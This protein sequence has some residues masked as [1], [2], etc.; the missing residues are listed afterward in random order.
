VPVHY[1]ARGF[2][3]RL[4]PRVPDTDGI[5]ASVLVASANSVNL[6]HRQ[7][8]CGTF[9]FALFLCRSRPG[10]DATRTFMTRI[11][12]ALLA[13]TLFCTTTVRGREATLP[14]SRKAGAQPL[15]AVPQVAVAVTDVRGELARDVQSGVSTPL[16]VAAEAAVEVSPATH[17]AWEVVP[18]GRI[19]RLRI[20]SSGATDLSLGFSRFRLFGG[21][22]LHLYSETEDY[23]QGAFTERDNK[24]HGQLW[25][26]VVPGDRLVIEL[27]VPDNG[28][29]PDLL[30]TQVNRGYRDLFRRKN[31]LGMP[32]AGVCENDVICTVGDPWRNEIRSVARY[33]VNGVFLCTGSLI[34]NVSGDKKNFFLTANHCGITAGNASSVVVYWNFESP[35]C[36]QQGGGSLAQNQS[37][38]TFRMSKADV[39]V[40]LIELEDVPDTAF[41][42]Y[43]AGWDRT[44]VA[45]PGAVGIHHPNGDEKS[46]SFSSATLLSV[47][48]CIGTGGVNTH[49][50]VFWNDGVTEPGSS[51]SGIWNP[52]TRRLVGFL[53]GGLSSCS[54]P[55][56]S[57]CYGKFSVAWDSGTTPASR[58]RD[59]LD[60]LNLN[61]NFVAGLDNVVIVPLTPSAALA[62]AALIGES[63]SPGNGVMDPNESVTVSF[64]VT[65][66]GGVALTNLVGTLLPGLGVSLPSGPQNY[67]VMPVGGANVSRSFTFIATGACGG[68]ITVRLQL[69]EG[70]VN[71]GTFTN[72]FT[73]GTPNIAMAQNFDAVVVPALPPGWTTSA[74]NSGSLW[75]STSAFRDTLPRSI[76]APAPASVGDSVVTSPSLF[77]G[78][79][80]AQLTF[81]HKYDF[82]NTYDGGVLEISIG[83]GAFVDILSSGGSFLA[84]GYTTTISSS[85]GN[86]LGGRMAWSGPTTG[87]ITTI[88]RLPAAA[89]GQ[90]VRLRWRAGTDSSASGVGW[91]VDTVSVSDG[92]VCC[93]GLLTPTIVNLRR[94]GNNVAFSFPSAAGQIYNVEFKGSLGTTNWQL[95]QSITGDGAVKHLTNS[96]TT[97]N[98]F[99]RLRSP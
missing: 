26:P 95:L 9:R 37:G 98:R 92:V 99:F 35:V 61:S 67:G 65:N 42:V 41:G 4:T 21:A 13:A 12:F 73:L 94:I 14:Y 59:W 90:S 56:E 25:T 81:R 43:Y 66:T 71:L 87:F 1:Q 46:I 74:T 60:P 76:F 15:A 20:I 58:L 57:D 53:S 75:V 6:A 49:W 86:S 5:K 31:E 89:A 96:F 10:Q 28:D 79:T 30:L 22:T 62:G 7:I 45:S 77:V 19:W 23:T 78:T 40:A 44:A 17:G 32:K 85:F 18:G 39:D 51:G 72:T 3:A 52:V 55:E 69:Q 80:T 84:G 97:T 88:A 63:C 50:R 8:V 24:P 70:A 33:T 54:L 82:E 16:R 2:A 47:N 38:A 68:V 29:V 91:Y 36:G 93:S 11:I 64:T 48:S 27:F 34:N 83:A